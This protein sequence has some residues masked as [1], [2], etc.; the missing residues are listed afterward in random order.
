MASWGNGMNL[1]NLHYLCKIKWA[2]YVNDR[3]TGFSKLSSVV[4]A[5]QISTASRKKA[6]NTTKTVKRVIYVVISTRTHEWFN[7][8]KPKLV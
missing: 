1:K 6:F 7:P 4:L 5:P 8:L 2:S 3:T